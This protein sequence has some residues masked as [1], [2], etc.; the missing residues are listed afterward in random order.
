M[1]QSGSEVTAQVAQSIAEGTANI[2]LIAASANADVYAVDMGI[3]NTTA[4]A[5]MSCALLGFTP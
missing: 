3:G 5:A 4:S 2:N 1:S